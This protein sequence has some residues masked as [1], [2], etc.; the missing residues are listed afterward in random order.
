MMSD[1][2]DVGQL[3][4]PGVLCV[5]CGY[6]LRGTPRDGRCPECGTLVAVSEQQGVSTPWRRFIKRRAGYVW[7]GLGICALG[8]AISVTYRQRA[9]AVET[10]VCTRCGYVQYRYLTE[11]RFPYSSREVLRIVR[12]TDQGH[13]YCLPALLDPEGQCAHQWSRLFYHSTSDRFMVDFSLDSFPSWDKGP[14]LAYL[15]ENAGLQSEILD[16]AASKGILAARARVKEVYESW[17][18]ARD[19]P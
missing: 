15:H 18:R 5:Q 1:N 17:L 9:G 14:F 19:E 3:A 8:F 7:L 13:D 2:G 10:R 4:R 16:L 12:Q 11:L 6:D